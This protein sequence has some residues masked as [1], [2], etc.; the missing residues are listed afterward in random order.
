VGTPSLG[1]PVLNIHYWLPFLFQK[2]SGIENELSPV[3]KFQFIRIYGIMELGVAL[4]FIAG[5]IPQSPCPQ[6]QVTLPS[7]V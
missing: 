1:V 2:N 3:A 6:E 4:T 5:L 7:L